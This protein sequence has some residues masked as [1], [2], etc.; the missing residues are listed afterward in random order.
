MTLGNAK[1]NV[2]DS[3]LYQGIHHE[4]A[5]FRSNVH[6]K[7]DMLV[8][9]E[10]DNRKGD[11]IPVEK[12]LSLEAVHYNSKVRW[13]YMVTVRD[14]KIVVGYTSKKKRS[15]AVNKLVVNWE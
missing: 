6:D 14:Y 4:L 10:K 7:I 1:L 3:V 12:S 9:Y 2:L 15:K 13:P 11:C 8:L 5:S